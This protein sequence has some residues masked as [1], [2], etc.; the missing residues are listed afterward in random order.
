MA[1]SALW[2][3]DDNNDG[4]NGHNGEV[5]SHAQVQCDCHNL[6]ECTGLFEV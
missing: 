6:L 3:G 1:L 2:C 5:Q 4:N